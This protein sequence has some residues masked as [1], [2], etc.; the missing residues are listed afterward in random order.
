MYE[1]L[2]MQ[3]ETKT[4][5]PLIGIGDLYRTVRSPSAATTTVDRSIKLLVQIMPWSIT[6][7]YKRKSGIWE[8]GDNKAWAA[9][10]KVMGYT[11]NN[12]NPAEAIKS[13]QGSFAK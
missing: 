4:Y 7:E 8:K 2:R 9:F 1:A 12:F 11:G 6:E 10:L 13:F 3:S 5:L